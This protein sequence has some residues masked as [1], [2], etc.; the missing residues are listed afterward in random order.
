M[1]KTLVTAAVIIAVVLVIALYWNLQ[2]GPQSDL[3]KVRFKHY[4]FPTALYGCEYSAKEKGFFAEEGLDVEIS[5]GDVID[6]TEFE[7]AN[8]SIDI[9]VGVSPQYLRAKQEG[10]PIIA[11][12]SKFQKSPVAYMVWEQ[13][14]IKSVK[15][16][17]G[18]RLGY[19]EGDTTTFILESLLR[20][21][22]IKDEDVEWVALGDSYWL[23]FTSNQIDVLPTYLGDQNITAALKGFD[24]RI[25]TGDSLGYNTSTDVFIT[26]ERMVKENPEILQKFLRAVKK[27][28]GFASEHPKEAVEIIKKFAPDEDDEYLLQSWT[29]YSKLI[30][31]DYLTEKDIFIQTEEQWKKTEQ[32]LVENNELKQF[33]PIE[34]LFT[35]QFL[36]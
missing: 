13:S 11:I 2:T 35:N 17:K 21:N 6:T 12:G 26:S 23:P 10:L 25:F 28:C 7:L 8:N 27:G 20:E 1:K 33:L 36:N 30:K 18:M 31:P 3:T 15:D 14:G 22:G 32:V 5:S 34:T 16:F 29:Q 24:V 9:A 19:W 4:W